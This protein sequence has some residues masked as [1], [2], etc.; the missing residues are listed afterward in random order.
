MNTPERR[1]SARV[2]IKLDV[3]FRV[4]GGVVASGTVENISRE[5]LLLI[6]PD[7]LHEKAS[8]LVEFH[9][10]ANK[11]KYEVKG[12]VVRSAPAGRFGVSFVH[13]DEAALAYVRDL[14]GMAQPT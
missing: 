12:V 4:D 8:V 5:G 1:H 2:K 7:A 3:T 10:S 9:D 14:V 13:V 6:A 11:R